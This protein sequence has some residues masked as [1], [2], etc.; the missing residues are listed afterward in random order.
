L[1]HDSIMS[2]TS[3]CSSVRPSPSL[4]PSLSS[5]SCNHG[6]GGLP[7]YN[8][9]FKKEL[10]LETLGN[11]SK[12][13][14]DDICDNFRNFLQLQEKKKRWRGKNWVTYVNNILSISLPQ[15]RKCT[16]C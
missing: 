13:N 2:G 8:T 6:H 12:Q 9:V 16:H 7:F 14:D 10:T 15:T 1:S 3:S 5:K 11:T 4:L